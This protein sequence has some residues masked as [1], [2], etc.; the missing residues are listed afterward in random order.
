[1]GWV[2]NATLQLIYPRDS[3]PVPILQEAGWV[4]GPNCVVGTW[5]YTIASNDW[6]ISE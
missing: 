1:M 5:N 6:V 2:V 4:P 3:D